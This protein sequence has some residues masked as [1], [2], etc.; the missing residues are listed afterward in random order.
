MK[1]KDINPVDMHII[2]AYALDIF[3]PIFFLILSFIVGFLLDGYDGLVLTFYIW[4]SFIAF[5][6]CN[7]ALFLLIKYILVFLYLR[8]RGLNE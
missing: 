8:K 2:E 4:L 7:F 3:F 5:I 1:M 6:I